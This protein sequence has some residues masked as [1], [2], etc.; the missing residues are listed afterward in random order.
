[1]INILDM[2]NCCDYL[3]ASQKNTAVVNSVCGERKK[4]GLLDI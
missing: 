1:M 4:A 3:R 2:I